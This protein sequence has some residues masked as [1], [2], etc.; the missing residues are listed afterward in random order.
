MLAVING[1]ISY[2]VDDKR[3]QCVRDL[4]SVCLELDPSQ[5]PNIADVIARSMVVLQTVQ[6]QQQ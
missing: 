2:P 6:Q 1:S 4:I 5:R 3:P